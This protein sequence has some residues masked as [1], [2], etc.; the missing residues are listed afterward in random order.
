[1][2]GRGESRLGILNDRM[3]LAYRNRRILLPPPLDEFPLKAFI[4]IASLTRTMTLASGFM[5]TFAADKR[6][7][8]L[9]G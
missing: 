3:L 7:H 8:G 2:R 6:A 5:A 4:F 1:M 9:S